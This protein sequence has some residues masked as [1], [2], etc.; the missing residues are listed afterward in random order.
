MF[1]C[2]CAKGWGGSTCSSVCTGNKY[3]K[4]CAQNCNCDATRLI[5]NVADQQCDIK[6]G[7]CKCNDNFVGATCEDRN[8]CKENPAICGGQPHVVCENTIGSYTCDCEQ[9]YRK[10]SNVCTRY[11]EDKSVPIDQD[12]EIV[13]NANMAIGTA[14]DCPPGLE[15]KTVY[16]ETKTKIEKAVKDAH[17]ASKS[18]HAFNIRCGSLKYELLIVVDKENAAQLSKELSSTSNQSIT[19]DGKQLSVNQLEV[20]D[21]DVKRIHSDTEQ[22]CAVFNTIEQCSGDYSCEIQNGLPTCQKNEKEGMYNIFY[23]FC[24]PLPH[25]IL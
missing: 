25:K 1:T 24:E 22:T 16:N 18:V 13:V 15:K 14:G 7:A 5:E 10:E 17:P 4:N 19:Y 23:C 6:E 9:F 11:N 12:K 21:V 2:D 8:E 3:G 20:N